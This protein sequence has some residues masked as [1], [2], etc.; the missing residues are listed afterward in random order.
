[1]IKST[2]L[3]IATIIQTADVDTPGCRNVSANDRTIPPVSA[4]MNR[5]RTAT[6]TKAQILLVHPF[7]RANVMDKPPG[8]SSLPVQRQLALDPNCLQRS[9]FMLTS[10]AI[11]QFLHR[12]QRP[13]GTVNTSAN[14][15]GY[16]TTRNS[17]TI[18]YLIAGEIDF[19]KLNPTHSK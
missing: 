7:G 19:G 14:Q 18:I 17:I 4:D 16:R 2:Y 12:V 8:P 5:R 15:R 11:F 6:I 13:I 10:R 9:H 3:A 1:L